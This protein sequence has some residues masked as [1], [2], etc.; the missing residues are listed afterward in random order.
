MIKITLSDPGTAAWK[1]WRVRCQTAT[2]KLRRTVESGEKWEV[3][4]LY[5]SK[6]IKREFFFAKEGPFGG[7]CAYC[8]CY[9]NDFQHP[10]IDHF[11]PK[12]GVTDKDDNPAVVFDANGNKSYH[13]GYYWLAYDAE[14]LLPTCKI[15]NEPSE[16]DGRKIGKH[17]RFPVVKDRYAV[18]PEAIPSEKPLLINPTCEDPAAHLSVDL[19][20]GLMKHTSPRGRMCIRI[21]GLNLRD[22]L[23][24]ERKKAID[25]VKA[26]L[27]TILHNPDEAAKQQAA[28]ELKKISDGKYAYAAA[29]RA[30]LASVRQFVAPLWGA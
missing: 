3:T 13:R 16:I 10:D 23:V 1:R 22:Q 17:N 4:N 26:K 5:K 18:I 15:C 2:K 7:R 19:A 21:F 9:L 29:G 12:K 30:M 27:E 6:T 14:N 11:R 25:E 20:T 28:Y 8:E 24:H